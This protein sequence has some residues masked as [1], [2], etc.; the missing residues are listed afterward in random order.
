MILFHYHFFFLLSDDL[1]HY[2]F[3]QI[4][5]NI[6]DLPHH[7][8]NNIC[9]YLSFVDVINLSKTCR[10]FCILI[11]NNDYFWMMLIQNHFGSRLYHR[12]LNE[13]FQNK[14]NS[15]YDLFRTEEDIQKFQKDFRRHL[16]QRCAG[17][18]FLLPR[19]SRSVVDSLTSSRPSPWATSIFLP[20]PA[21]PRYI[22]KPVPPVHHVANWFS[23]PARPVNLL[24]GPAPPVFPPEYF[25]QQLYFLFLS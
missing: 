24:A 2:R 21:R 1:L 8:L 23:H 10:K 12:Y 3:F 20:C 9:K 17:Q 19:G 11:E 7:V 16:E 14:K 13:I 5:M 15:D 4:K 6:N 18:H 25:Y 22:L